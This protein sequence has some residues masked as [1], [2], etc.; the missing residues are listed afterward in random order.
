LG[1]Q[2]FDG[3]H[4]VT[5]AVRL[6][7]WCI[8]FWYAGPFVIDGLIRVFSFNWASTGWGDCRVD[9]AAA[10]LFLQKKSP[11]T[12]EALASMG[13]S[14]YGFGHPPTTSFWFIPFTKVD[15]PVMS[16]L[17]GI[18]TLVAL[19]FHLI[20]CANELELP[21]KAAFVLLPFGF[22]L[23]TTWLWDHLTL[24]QVSEIIAFLFALSW[25]FL[26]RG[27][28]IEAGIT[29]GAACTFKL[30]PGVLVLFLLLTRRFR[31]AAAACVTYL[32][33][34][35]F[36]TM[37]YGLRA[38]T[39]FFHQQGPISAYWMGHIRNASLHGIV[40]RLFRPLC[41]RPVDDAQALDII[42]ALRKLPSIPAL[43][44][45]SWAIAASL[46]LLAFC[47]WI[48]KR[49]AFRSTSID[50]PY[51]LFSVVAVFVNP[52]I[53]EHY[54]VLLFTPLFVLTAGALRR[55]RD[56]GRLVIDVDRPPRM[57]TR[58][59]IE[60]L[61]LSAVVLA[62]V[63]MLVLSTYTKNELY[64][65]YW[66]VQNGKQSLPPGLHARMHW[67]EMLNWLP[68]VVAI[69]G[70]IGLTFFEKPR[71]RLPSAVS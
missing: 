57:L 13:L 60:L 14:N 2:K 54:L 42:G 28:E 33:I 48:S 46:L 32:V 62:L 31:G 49:E 36:M 53:W 10:R 26:R 6:T 65:Q 16:E 44:G 27:R 5:T 55:A 40:V 45:S 41:E 21:A 69:A 30:F 37:G 52:W 67:W 43:P 20:I 61:F 34:A 68:W 15:Y 38:W 50:V 35:V 7:A 29:L 66:A 3:K 59:G 51:T 9:W 63:A 12:E 70:L 11:Y 19:L 4:S 23:Q 24:V 64:A 22:A 1:S 17:V 18:L 58:T 25:Y 8:F 47:W 71:G 56:L 39:D